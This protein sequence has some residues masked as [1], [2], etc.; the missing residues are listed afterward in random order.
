MSF[1]SRISSIFKKDDE[2]SKPVIKTDLNDL[3]HQ[4]KNLSVEEKEIVK[5]ALE[6]TPIELV[7]LDVQESSVVQQTATETNY[8]YKKEPYKRRKD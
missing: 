3:I 1:L 4:I 2:E 6:T 7:E 8:E 5:N